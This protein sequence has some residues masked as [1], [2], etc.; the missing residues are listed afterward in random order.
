MVYAYGAS[1]VALKLNNIFFLFHFFPQGAIFQH[2]SQKKN[3]T[4]NS[5]FLH[6]TLQLTHSTTPHSNIFLPSICNSLVEFPH[7]FSHHLT[8]LKKIIIIK[9]S[10]SWEK[11][12]FKIFWFITKN[13][14]T[15]NMKQTNQPQPILFFGTTLTTFLNTHN[16]THKI[17]F[18]KSFP[19]T[20]FFF[21]FQF[22]Y[23]YSHLT[24]SS[25]VF[26][27]VKYKHLTWWAIARYIQFPSF[28]TLC[29]FQSLFSIWFLKDAF[30]VYIPVYINIENIYIY[31]Y[32]I[33]YTQKSK[34]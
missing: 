8:P 4:F 31:I 16:N 9:N 27:F 26:T 28:A 18:G 21:S 12:K 10:S 6:T 2:W 34:T 5:L 33:Y 25:N 19:T 7:V 30:I 15:T 17:T 13:Q 11:N 23:I 22:Y 32:G 14:T 20:L 24:E 29:N 3:G 1:G